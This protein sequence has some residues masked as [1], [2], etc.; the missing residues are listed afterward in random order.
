M[1]VSGVKMIRNRLG[2]PDASGRRKADPGARLGVRPRRGHGHLGIRPV[3]RHLVDS[4][5]GAW[6]GGQPL[7]HP[8]G[9]P[10]HLDD[11]PPGLFAGGD[12]TEGSRNLIS[13]IADGR[14]AAAAI[15]RYLGGEDNPAEEAVEIELPDFRRGMVD[16]Y[17]SIPYQ[18]FRRCR[19]RSAS[20][21]PPRP[22]PATARRKRSHRRGAACNAS[23]TS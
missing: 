15:N 4:G 17:E 8:A 7:G 22:R 11:Q 14:D 12:F 13:A 6:A 21:S 19:C 1:H 23:S 10:R 18:T 16:D 2:D 20:A 9:G 5:A 3:R